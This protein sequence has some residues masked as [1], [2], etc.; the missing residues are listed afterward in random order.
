MLDVSSV[1]VAGI[2]KANEYEERKTHYFMWFALASVITTLYL[3]LSLPEILP[4][5]RRFLDDPV[6]PVHELIHLWK[7]DV[8]APASDTAKMLKAI[9]EKLHPVPVPLIA[10]LQILSVILLSMIWFKAFILRSYSKEESVTRNWPILLSLFP[11]MIFVMGMYQ[12]YQP[13][14]FVM[15][16]VAIYV[17]AEH[18]GSLE[19]QQ[20][21]L[22][23]Q[24]QNLAAQEQILVKQQALLAQQ[25]QSLTTQQKDLNAAVEK[26][27]K[28]AVN[29]GMIVRNMGLETFISQVYETYAKA[30][31][32]SA[33]VRF[34]DIDRTWWEFG[35]HADPWERYIETVEQHPSPVTLV[36]ALGSKRIDGKILTRAQFIADLP[37]PLSSEWGSR[38]KSDKH[39]LFQDIMGLAWQLEVMGIVRAL[40]NDQQLARA[41][42]SRPLSWIHVTDR[43][44]FQII[45]RKKILDSSVQKL[46]TDEESRSSDPRI[47][48]LSSNLIEW[49]EGDIQRYAERGCAAEE[50][51]FS[52]LRWASID[53][54]VR[55]SDE[56]YIHGNLERVLDMLGLDKWLSEGVLDKECDSA[57]SKERVRELCIDIFK[58]LIERTLHD[59]VCTLKFKNATRT[60]DHLAYEVL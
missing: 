40:L 36:N 24:Q 13:A 8:V 1:V 51:I 18:F 25:Q 44:V 47:R 45:Q 5:L 3:I 12:A 32:I 42:I 28:V 11:A 10:F 34:H 29:V 9:D 17:A 26:I 4:A 35:K 43:V 57:G 54:P 60:V 16:L 30:K 53:A 55:S 56:L 15:A 46:V 39:W 33:V 22:R 21:I 14:V 59:D 52:L 48:I 50:Y 58:R 27:E 41:W 38:F 20:K 7:G 19:A 37:L 2:S 23:E 31:T 49:A 6:K